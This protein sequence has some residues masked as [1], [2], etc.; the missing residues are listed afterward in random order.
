MREA[1]MMEVLDHPAVVKFFGWFETE[2]ELAFISELMA[3][4]LADRLKKY[5]KLPYPVLLSA[6]YQVAN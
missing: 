1:A 3:M 2:T 6:G 5:G 4:S